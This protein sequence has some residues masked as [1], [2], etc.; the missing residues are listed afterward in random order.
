MTSGKASSASSGVVNLVVNA[1]SCSATLRAA[2]KSRAPVPMERVWSS[3]PYVF[4]AGLWRWVMS[5]ESKHGEG[6]A[7]E[8]QP[9][10]LGR[11]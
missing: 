4:F 6:A 7:T 3:A 5:G 10:A 11:H 9:Q 1:S 8:H 2:T